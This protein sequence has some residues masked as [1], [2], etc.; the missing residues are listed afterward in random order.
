[1]IRVLAS[2]VNFHSSG[3]LEIVANSL[4]TQR[5]IGE[6]F[7]VEVLLSDNS[8]EISSANRLF[9]D[10]YLRSHH[11]DGFAAPNNRAAEIALKEGFDY[12]LLINPDCAMERNSLARLIAALEWDRAAGAACPKLLRADE[13]LQPFSPPLIDGTGIYFTPTLRHFDRGS[14]ELDRGQFDRSNY[15]FGASGACMLVSARM[16]RDL[17]AYASDKHSLLFDESFFAYREDA[18]LAW[19]MNLR[20][21]RTRYEPSAV[22]Y[23]IRQVTHRNRSDHSAE[24]KAYSVR[25]RFLL[26]LNNWEPRKNLPTLLPALVRNFVIRCA[27]YLWER[28]SIP[29]LR[30]ASAL[31]P[32]ALRTRRVRLSSARYDNRTLAR[33][34]RSKP[35]AEPAVSTPTISDLSDFSPKVHAI[36]VNYQSGDRLER[37]VSA[38]TSIKPS[39]YSLK[40]SVV[41][42]SP[43]PVVLGRDD[44]DYQHYTENLGFAGAIN[45]VAANVAADYLLILNPDVVINEAALTELVRGLHTH[46]DL[47]AIAPILTDEHDRAQIGFTIKR[48]PT[49]VSTLVELLGLNGRGSFAEQTLRYGD[50]PLLLQYLH[51]EGNSADSVEPHYRRGVPVAVAQPA[52]ACLL[53]RAPVLRDLGGFDERFYPAWFEDV[54]LC[55]R[56]W[57][58]GLAAAVLDTARVVHEGGYTVKTLGRGRVSKLYFQN[59]A[60]Y[61]DKHG[62]I[63]ERLMVMALAAVRMGIRSGR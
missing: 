10:R 33:W 20:G 61:W 37:C 21:W 51:G 34:F 63:L 9:C 28:S 22:G 1:M 19:R 2:I 32:V 43:R 8:G 5:G 35:Y 24:V 6:T 47:A 54:D 55:K 7:T 58:D 16:L 41:D 60:R 38:L 45:R 27:V 59:M 52:A 18:D 50:D 13:A 42:N 25:N 40:I 53:L 46:Q 4:R 14:G 11:N 17:S 31:V 12:L 48:L 23:H 62:N 26:L 3:L 15:V 49:L 56:L 30:A 57:D 29:A 36:V 44:I 39:G